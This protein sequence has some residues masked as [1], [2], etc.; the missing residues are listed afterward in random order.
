M[1]PHFRFA[2]E[3]APKLSFQEQKKLL[4][5]FFA[6]RYSYMPSLFL[7]TGAM[8]ALLYLSEKISFPQYGHYFNGRAAM[9]LK[10]YGE[11]AEFFKKCLAVNPDDPEYQKQYKLAQKLQEP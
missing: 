6:D 8:F 1:P 10:K 4:K 11:A 3:K 2:D 7:L 9:V 5:A